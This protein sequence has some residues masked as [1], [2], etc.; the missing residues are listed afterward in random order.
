MADRL[1]LYA[2]TDD[3]LRRPPLRRRSVCG[4]FCA[5]L[6]GI[7]VF[8]A[9]VHLGLIAS[10]RL[11]VAGVFFIAL[12]LSS[13]LAVLPL[14]VLWYLDRRERKTPWLFAAAFLWGG[15][16]ATAIALPF[17]TAFFRFVDAWVAVNPII[18]ELLGPDAA[19]LLA[20]PISAPIAEE[21]AKALGVVVIFRLLR[22]EFD[23]MREG[24]VYG[25]LVGL[26]FN[27]FEAALYVAQG[28]A[29]HGVA[30]Y[31]LQ[32]GGRYALFGF[33]GHALFTGLFG[34]ALGLAIQ[35]QRR[36]LRIVA[37]IGGIILAI[38]GHM[39]NNALPL[40]ATIA[41]I[42]AG[43]PLTMGQEPPP[44]IGF[45]DAFISSSVLQLVIF[46]PLIVILAVALW[47]SSVWERKVVREELSDE[48][49]D[50]VSPREH[51]D[52]LDDGLFQT[53][54][55]DPARPKASAALVNAQHE[56]AF[57]KRRVRD[58]GSNPDLDWRT[59]DWRREIQ[60]LRTAM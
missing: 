25:A 57:R 43:E 3:L 14:A 55:I 60:R 49:G 7:L 47:R 2:P 40:L 8:S 36:W 12:V 21:I 17:N 24:I 5:I 30:P 19:Q 34:A 50:A 16:I 53:R 18:T 38:G 10:M 9:L 33:G 45:I 58:K 1:V 15:C 59:E 51:R 13:I 6:L 23:T 35:T 39:F 11:D 4:P 26:G 48:A 46:L 22:D 27:W 41:S 32:L 29:Q 54:R 44:D 31:G 37:P 28:Y 20:A 52:I 42:A 56:L